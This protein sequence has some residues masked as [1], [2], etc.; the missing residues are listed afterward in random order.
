M[1]VTRSHTPPFQEFLA[2]HSREGKGMEV[3]SEQSGDLP[4]SRK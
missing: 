3:A 1:G 2:E 4:Q